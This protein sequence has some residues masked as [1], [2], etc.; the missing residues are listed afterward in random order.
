MGTQ[1]KSNGCGEGVGHIWLQIES[2]EIAIIGTSSDF[3]GHHV[4]QEKY[5]LQEF[6]D[7]VTNRLPK[8]EEK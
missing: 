4:S 5:G 7:Q 8:I 3:L 6:Q 2:S 1:Q